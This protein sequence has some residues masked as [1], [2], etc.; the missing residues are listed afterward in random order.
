MSF[1]V[2]SRQPCSSNHRAPSV[3]KIAWALNKGIK[4]THKKFWDVERGVTYIPWNKVKVEE[5]ESFREGGMLD[6]DSINPGKHCIIILYRYGF[7]IFV[8]LPIFI[9][10]FFF[11]RF[12]AS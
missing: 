2:S 12:Y 11:F 7:L 3:S 1:I 9:V 6:M 10:F 5:L 8:G 4:S